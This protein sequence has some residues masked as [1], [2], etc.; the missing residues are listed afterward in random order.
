MR[1]V[2][3]VS[4]KGRD[5]VIKN[6]FG[7]FCCIAFLFGAFQ[8]LRT[9]RAEFLLDLLADRTAQKIRFSK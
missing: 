7:K 4:G 6:F 9:L 2:E 8:K 3:S 5:D 1:L